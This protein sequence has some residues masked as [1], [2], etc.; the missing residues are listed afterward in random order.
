VIVA[1]IMAMAD[2]LGLSVV[3]EGV[4]TEAQHS[5][6]R[7]LGGRFAQGY[8]YARPLPPAEAFALVCRDAIRACARTDPRHAPRV[9]PVPGA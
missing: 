7:E 9:V 5:R 2:A 6:L 4:E 1:A 3:A 8:L